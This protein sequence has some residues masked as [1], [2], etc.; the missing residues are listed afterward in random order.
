MIKKDNKDLKK[1]NGKDKNGNKK[2]IH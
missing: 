2:G 1:N